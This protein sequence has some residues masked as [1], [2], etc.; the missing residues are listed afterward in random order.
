MTKISYVNGSYVNHADAY[1]HI[2]DRGYQF[3][4][5]V[6]EVMAFYNRR[7]LD[8]DM[9][10]QRLSRS[11]GELRIPEPMTGRAMRLVMREIMERNTRESG[12]LYI[13][14]TR[15]TARRDHVFPENTPPNLVMVVTGPKM[16]KEKDIR[17]G[18]SVITLPDIRWARRDIKSISLLANILA[19]QS[20]TE[21]VA[22]EAWLYNKEGIISEGSSSNNAIVNNKGEIITSP[23]DNNIL[24]GITRA[25]ILDIARKN[26]FKV[27]EKSF[28]RKEATAA[29]EAFMMSTTLNILPVTT[30]D[31]AKVADGKPGKT[32]LRLLELY[33]EHIYQQ[34][35][36]KW[37]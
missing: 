5:G 21:A 6:Y 4:D 32:T 19:K 31:G 8:A 37:G 30:I 16:P 2:E 26:G 10:M 14:I 18:A 1:T 9:H 13:Q 11:L 23:A 36:K 34:T 7:L 29:K 12:T 3:A 24:G 27:I 17:N 35:G 15:G 20:A 25:V 22:K 33:H 28:S